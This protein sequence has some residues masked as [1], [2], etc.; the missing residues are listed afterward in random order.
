MNFFILFIK[1]CTC[2]YNL[3]CKKKLIKRFVILRKKD[4][5]KTYKYG[6]RIIFWFVRH[7]TPWFVRGSY[8][9][10]GTDTGV[11]TLNKTFG[12]TFATISFR[13]VLYYVKNV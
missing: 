13:V 6:I 1:C 8:F 9:I 7:D 4:I 11:F 12:S 10:H 5:I 3:S 2:Y